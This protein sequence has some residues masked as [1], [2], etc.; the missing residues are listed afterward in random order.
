[1]KP[2]DLLKVHAPSVVEQSRFHGRLVIILDEKTHVAADREYISVFCDGP[3]MMPV[4][5]LKEI[6]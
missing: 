5:W 6:P 3:R 2:G 1:M 4:Y